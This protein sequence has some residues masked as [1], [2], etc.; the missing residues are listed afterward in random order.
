MNDTYDHHRRRA[1]LLRERAKPLFGRDPEPDERAALFAEAAYE[2][3]RANEAIL[4]SMFTEIR[5]P[6]KA[7]G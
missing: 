3:A 1:D 4:L 7:T 2:Q 6:A 5:R